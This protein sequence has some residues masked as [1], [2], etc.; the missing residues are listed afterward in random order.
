MGF[1]LIKLKKLCSYQ[2]FME[3]TR[4]RGRQ[5]ITFLIPESICTYLRSGGI[6]VESLISDDHEWFDLTMNDDASTQPAEYVVEVFAVVDRWKNKRPEGFEVDTPKSGPE[7]LA[8][9]TRAAGKKFVKYRILR[10]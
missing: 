1:D 10:K 5:T 4:R 9:G 6:E 3:L 8:F 7:I 2:K